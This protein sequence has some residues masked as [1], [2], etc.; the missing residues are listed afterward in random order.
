M[1]TP[2]ALAEAKS[3]A[4]DMV[5]IAPKAVPPVVK[6]INYDKYRYQLEKLAR[7]QRKHQKKVEVKGVRLS[8]RIGEHDLKVK[9]ERAE[10]FLKE[11]NKVKIDLLLRGRERGNASQAIE[12]IHKFLK[13]LALPYTLEQAPARMGHMINAILSPKN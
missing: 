7:Q 2:Q 6:L 13:L 12:Q 8:A 3:K 10:K 1:P 5:E 11:G 9:A 4:L